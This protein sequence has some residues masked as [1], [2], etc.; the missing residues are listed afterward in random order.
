M[1]SRSATALAAEKEINAKARK[2]P[3]AYLNCRDMRHAWD[4]LNDFYVLKT[5]QVGKVVTHVGRTLQCQRCPTVRK[6]TY[7]IRKNG[8]EKIS[9]FYEYPE[10]YLFQGVPRGVKPSWIFQ[11]E[12]YRRAVRRAAGALPGEPEGPER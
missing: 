5:I 3:D 11:Q 7:I 6:E 4:I 9:Q 10:D 8:L 2:M 1:V 12:Q